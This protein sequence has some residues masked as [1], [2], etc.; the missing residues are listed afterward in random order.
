VKR[1]HR[2]SGFEIVGWT[3]LGVVSGLVAGFALSEWVGGV[4]RPRVKR[5]VRRT[6]GRPRPPLSPAACARAAAAALAAD[7]LLRDLSL[8]ATAVAVGVV[9]LHGWVL[10]RA[11]RA[12]AGRAARAVPGIDQV[13]NR[14]LV[15]GEDDL[16]PRNRAAD[17][18]A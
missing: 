2:L 4:S 9:E 3:G 11:L 10:T 12:R 7:P 15:R 1:D 16:D 5:L 13:V 14:I 6:P 18:S 17:Q 8:D